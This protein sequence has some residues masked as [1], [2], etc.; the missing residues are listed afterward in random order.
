VKLR[1]LLYRS[2]GWKIKGSWQR[3]IIVIEGKNTDY[4]DKRINERFVITASAVSVRPPVISRP[5]TRNPW[6]KTLIQRVRGEKSL[7]TNLIEPL[8]IQQSPPYRPLLPSPT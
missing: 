5:K 1:T 8:A 4:Q 3:Y 6:G 7:S 2:P